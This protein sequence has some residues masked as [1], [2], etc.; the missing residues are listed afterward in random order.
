MLSELTTTD[1]LLVTPPLPSTGDANANSVRIIIHGISY[2]IIL[3]RYV[4]IIA[5]HKRKYMWF[6]TEF[7]A[8]PTASSNSPP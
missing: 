1:I 8:S 7:I 2:Y 4:L 6:I 5:Y 3:Y